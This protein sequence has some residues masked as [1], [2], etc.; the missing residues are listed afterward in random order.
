[1]PSAYTV[2]DTT[3]ALSS[4]VSKLYELERTR[5]ALFVD[6]EGYELG[7]NGRLALITIYAL[8]LAMTYIV[9]V[10]TLEEASFTTEGEG[11]P[12]KTLKS[13]LEDN[14]IPKVLY[15]CRGDND[16][17]YNLY[18]VDMRGVIDLQLMELATRATSPY[19]ANLNGLARTIR[20]YADLPDQALEKWERV[21]NYGKE[22]FESAGPQTLGLFE[23]RPLSE[24]VIEYS[25][26]DTTILPRLYD[27]FNGLIQPTWRRRVEE[28]TSRRLQ[29]A[30]QTVFDGSNG[31]LMK[32]GPWRKSV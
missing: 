26:Q 27:R 31:E 32:R 14:S 9:D 13:L 29:L 10:T 7:R 8:P 2:V 24:K 21:K 23:V 11:L 18:K 19:G 30:R 16:A 25:I 5:P 3:Q 20:N 28:E 4:F 12:G 17:L 22:I 1:M 6:L 15:D